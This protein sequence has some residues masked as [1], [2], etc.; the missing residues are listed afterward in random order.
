MVYN[1][2]LY[3]RSFNN[4]Y[5]T[6]YQIGMCEVGYHGFGFLELKINW[7]PIE[8]INGVTLKLS[9]N[10]EYDYGLIY[11]TTII[12]ASGTG[13]IADTRSGG[14]FYS[15]DIEDSELLYHGAD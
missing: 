4:N 1:P 11:Y 10:S 5:L 15:T 13:F 6:L 2:L 7:L 8:C 9:T 14:I 12:R 3:R